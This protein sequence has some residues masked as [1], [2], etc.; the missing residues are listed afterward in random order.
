MNFVDQ[1]LVYI[2][3]NFDVQLEKGNF[4]EIP[5]FAIKF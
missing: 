1:D 3:K 4:L 5:K 2:P